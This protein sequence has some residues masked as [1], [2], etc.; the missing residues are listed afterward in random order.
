MII[1]LDAQNKMIFVDGS[2]PKPQE[3][4]MEEKAWKRCNNLVTGW[5]IASLERHIAKSIMYF[6]TASAIGSDLERRFGNPSSSQMYRLQEQL[7][8]T[9][10]EPGMSIADYFTRVKSQWDEIDDLRP[11][12]VCTCNPTTN[13]LKIQQDQR[14]LTF[15]MKLDPEY[16]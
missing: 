5:L 13:F 3:G 7:L 10:Q 14:I 15:L 11:L 4:S 6:K 9:I 2:L 12:S 8:T 1:S 16:S